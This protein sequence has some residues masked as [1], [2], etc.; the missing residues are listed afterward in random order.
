MTY[1]KKF[2]TKNCI[3]I[4][5]SNTQYN[6]IQMRK[7]TPNLDTLQLNLNQNKLQRVID[8]KDWIHA[9]RN[10][11]HGRNFLKKYA[12]I[13]VLIFFS[14]SI[15]QNKLIVIMFSNPIAHVRKC[16]T[17]EIVGRD[18]MSEISYFHYLSKTYYYLSCT[19]LSIK[20]VP[21]F[22]FTNR[23]CFF[24]RFFLI[25]Q[26]TQHRSCQFKCV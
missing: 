25:H 13:F 5:T 9:F 18:T 12:L 2:F 22:L 4:K 24:S 20:K 7:S 23:I 8:S 11:K 14:C 10:S 6:T 1:K 15:I 19:H 21:K 17:F 3:Q 16:Y 26:E